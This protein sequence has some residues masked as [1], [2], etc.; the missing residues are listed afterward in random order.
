MSD[1]LFASPLEGPVRDELYQ[2]LDAAPAAAGQ[3][4]F[5]L[6]NGNLSGGPYVVSRG[7]CGCVRAH[8]AAALSV[9]DPFQLADPSLKPNRH[10]PL[11]LFLYD[12]SFMNV[13]VVQ[14]GSRP[15]DPNEAGRRLGL[16][17]DWILE[18]MTDRATRRNLTDE[19]LRVET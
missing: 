8:V 6:T 17:E 18:W 10:G 19:T 9:R 15:G 16:I 13:F 12:F 7:G 3:L 5:A 2:V 11:E 14:P 4:L 1:N